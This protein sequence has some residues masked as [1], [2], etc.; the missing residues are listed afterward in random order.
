MRLLFVMLY[1]GYLRYFD[2]LVDELT[3]RG[4][5]VD[6]VWHIPTRQAEGLVAL[7][8]NERVRVHV[9]PKRGT[10]L[11]ALV[12]RRLELTI[13]FVRYL[14]RR[15][16]AAG[17]LRRRASE[18][19]PWPF[20]RLRTLPDPLVRALLALL[21]ALDRVL[22]RPAAFDRFLEELRPDAV[23]VSP[24]VTK[25][26]PQALLVAAARERGIPTAAAIASWDNL[27]CKSIVTVPP[28]RM[29]VW[30]ETMRREAWEYHRFPA[31]RVIVTGAQCFDRWFGRTPRRDRT[32]FCAR[33]GLPGEPPYL[34]FV[35]S[36]ASIS[37]PDAEVEFVRAWLGRLRGDPVLGRTPVLI[38]PHPYNTQHWSGVDLSDVP[39]V[40][41]FP[42]GGAN[43]VADEDRADYFDSL[44]HAAAVVGVNTSAMIEAAVVGRPVL[45]VTDPEFHDSQLETMH[46][47]YLLPENGGFVRAAPSITAHLDQLRAVLADPEGVQAQ[48]ADFVGSFVR[49][50]GVDRPATPIVADVLE[51]LPA[52]DP[53]PYP[54]PPAWQR[55]LLSPLLLVPA[56][57]ELPT[58][59]RNR[60][61]RRA[62]RRE[63][64]RARRRAY[65]SRH[66]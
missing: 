10:G 7:E 29:L 30:N 36:T 23:V 9:L 35:G 63:R 8:G 59:A 47:H 66:L 65:A 49:P 19:V 14:D 18:R 57:L 20:S 44:Y 39:D 6:L 25:A 28:D 4:H 48:I 41:I 52:L 2:S 16:R 60:L 37:S 64:R 22:P 33:A 12:G 55:A 15:F 26:N 50:H 54:A 31:E 40:A 27:T 5:E 1:P 13:Y 3:A 51:A 61:R 24:L 56:L 32:A 43:P 62:R 11:W 17:Y 58:L 34:L 53:E 38:R 21:V 42:R 45:T 46:F